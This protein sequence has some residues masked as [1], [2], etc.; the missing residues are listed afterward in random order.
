MTTQSPIVST[1]L[2]TIGKEYF[3]FDKISN[4]EF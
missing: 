2:P 4:E 3:S 1:D